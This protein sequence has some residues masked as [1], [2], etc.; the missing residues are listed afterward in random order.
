MK[1]YIL[2]LMSLNQ[3]IKRRLP[4][5]SLLVLEFISQYSENFTFHQ[6]NSLALN[7]IVVAPMP[8]S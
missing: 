4:S 2:P 5:I 3:S 1:S 6:I 7:K 8:T